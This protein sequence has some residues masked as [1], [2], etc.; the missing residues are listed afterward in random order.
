M[1]SPAASEIHIFDRD[2]LTLR[3]KRTAKNFAQ[4][5]FLFRW[6]E[7]RIFESLP[8]IKRDFKNV[9]VIGG[10]YTDKFFDRLQSHLADDAAITLY[11]HD[12]SF[13]CNSPYPLVTG[14]E[15][16]LPFAYES[17]DL[18]LSNLNFHTINDLPGLLIQIRKTLKPDGLLIGSLFGG[19]SLF[20]LRESLTQ[21]EL[22]VKGGV[23]P[24]VHP[25]ATKQDMGALLQRAGYNLPVIDSDIVTVT[26][27]T[28]FKLMADLRGMGEANIINARNKAYVGRRLFFEA[29]SHYAQNFT[30]KTT[31]RIEAS[32]EVIFIHGWAPHESQQKP[33]QPGSAKNRMADALG[34]NEEKL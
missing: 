15:E 31:S 34:E 6:A 10:R 27:D 5:D 25:F 11:D 16:V 30:E 1:S 33:L 29:A 8:V 4:Y 32:F 19:E 22:Q 14:D 9:L 12:G 2:L 26:Y 7:D 24:R 18:I 20:E 17:F 3:R 13:H 28:M 21:A 23:S